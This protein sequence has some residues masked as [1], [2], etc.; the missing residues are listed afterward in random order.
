MTG[1]GRDIGRAPLS[2]GVIGRLHAAPYW[3]STP[4]NLISRDRLAALLVA[5][6][7]ID[8][9]RYKFRETSWGSGNMAPYY[10]LDGGIRRPFT[11]KTPEIFEL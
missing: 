8:L 3:R 9:R 11:V 1:A 2:F 7:R 6:G 4:T 10:Y 5:V